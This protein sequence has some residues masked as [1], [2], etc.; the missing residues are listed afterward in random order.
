VRA[1]VHAYVCVCAHAYARVRSRK[2]IP[3][4]LIIT[5]MIL[6]QMLNIV[7]WEQQIE[8]M[9]DNHHSLTE[10]KTYSYLKT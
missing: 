8:N 2:G 3:I 1:C 6:Q 9:L 4:L 5:M 10:T 7:Y